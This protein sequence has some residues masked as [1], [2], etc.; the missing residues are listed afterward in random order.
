MTKF[1]ST[2]AAAVLLAAS[3]AGCGVVADLAASASPKNKQSESSPVSTAVS[4]PYSV[5]PVPE[6]GAEQSVPAAG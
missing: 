3:L 4:E 1:I 5:L 6:S 2:L